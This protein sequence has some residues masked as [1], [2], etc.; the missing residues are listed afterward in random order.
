TLD[1]LFSISKLGSSLKIA[2]AQS[3]SVEL[4]L[5]LHHLSR[6][7]PS[8]TVRSGYNN[9]RICRMEV[10]KPIFRIFCSTSF[11]FIDKL[12]LFLNSSYN[13]NKCA[14]YHNLKKS[15]CA[16]R[17]E[18]ALNG[19][20]DKRKKKRIK[21]KINAIDSNRLNPAQTDENRLMPN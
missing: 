20:Q 21:N 7:V 18:I 5:S 19:K 8:L 3:L 15:F 2:L 1:F 14:Q 9:K 16:E 4:S 12:V 10:R 6:I 17:F 11:M 13:T